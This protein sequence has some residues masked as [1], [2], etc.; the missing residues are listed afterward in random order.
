MLSRRTLGRRIHDAYT[1]KME[2]IKT[3]IATQQAVCTTAD[4]WSTLQQGRRHGFES[5]GG[6]WPP[7]FGQWGGDKISLR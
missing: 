7:L 3:E 4:I 1:T 5:G 2:L 6:G